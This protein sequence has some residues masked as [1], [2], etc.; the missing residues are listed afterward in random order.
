MTGRD[1]MGRGTRF[2][3]VLF[4]MLGGRYVSVHSILLL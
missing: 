2:A 1:I 4:L 3:S